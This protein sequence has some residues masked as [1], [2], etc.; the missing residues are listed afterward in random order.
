[1]ILKITQYDT[2]NVK[3]F[4]SQLNNLKSGTKNCT[5]EL[6]IFMRLIF[7]TNYYQLIYKFRG[8]FCKWFIS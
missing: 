4:N 7:H 5:K 2:L 1:M 6:Q 8:F 3:L